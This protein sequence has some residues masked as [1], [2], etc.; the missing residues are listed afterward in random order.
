MKNNQP[1]TQK[2][3]PMVDGTILVSKTDPKGIIT[4][5]NDEF[6]R[7]SG[8]SEE[9]LIGRSHNIVRHPDMPPAAF[10]DLW[11]TIRR[12]EPWHGLV[13]NRTKHGDH[14][15]VYANVTPIF[16]NGKITGYMS[17]RTKPT[18]RQIDA[19]EERYRQMWKTQPD[20]PAEEKH[21]DRL[22]AWWRHHRFTALAGTT[23]LL[24]LLAIVI[25]AAGA[26]ISTI[27]PLM[28]LPLIPLGLLLLTIR[29]QLT[30]P[31]QTISDKLN[32]LLEGDFFD[33]IE[34]AN[35]DE[36][37]RIMR[38]LRM[39][40]IKLGFDVV[41]ANDTVLKLLGLVSKLDD[42]AQR[43][44]DSACSMEKSAANITEINSLVKNNS[45]NAIDA[46]RM[47]EHV[48]EQVK[49]SCTALNNAV[50]AMSAINESTTRIAD[51]IGVIDEIAFKTNLLALNAAVEA[52]HAGDQGKGFAVVADEV[53]NLSQLTSAAAS[54]VKQLIQDNID[55]VRDGSSMIDL[56]S[57]AL[58]QVVD[59]VEKVGKLI[60]EI[61]V[62]GKEQAIG[63]EMLSKNIQMINETLQHSS[64]MIQETS[65][66]SEQIGQRAEEYVEKSRIRTAA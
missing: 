44:R 25:A 22:N 1:V 35:D 34:P 64:H 27:V 24:Q 20:K 12:G 54:E 31:L 8:F 62:S 59:E 19:A 26:D 57:E 51:I 3:I 53:R 46:N 61:S 63:I 16:E 38:Q 2:E 55:K 32:S 50:N 43:F 7:I 29:R 14:Y 45:D 18:A 21:R 52:A 28:L 39:I 65:S 42:L 49:K 40:Q 36:L 56:S 66:Q 9:E 33:W 11:D 37:G 17:V 4:F 23:A 6:V 47:A 58:H 60:S 30:G 5:C 10:A 48:M 15:W 13:K 41:D